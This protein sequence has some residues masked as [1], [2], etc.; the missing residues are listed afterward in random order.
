M[1]SGSWLRGYAEPLDAISSKTGRGRWSFRQLLIASAAL[2]LLIVAGLYGRYW[3][4][5]GRFLI[6]TD[7]AYVRAHSVLI[8]PK[9][10]GY[11]AEVPVDDNQ[12]VRAGAVLAR[13]DPGDYQTALDQAR[14]NIAAAQANIDTINRQI[15][16][17]RFAVEQARQQIVSDQ[18]ALVYSQQ[19]SQRYTA[20][21]RTGYGTVQ[22]A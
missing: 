3:W 12:P 21:A 17:Q 22:M 6:S 20:L 10:S 8:S 4:T 16:E 14:A 19:N 9:V 7:D 13:I 1:M 18:A 11:I 2:L 15:E 5:T